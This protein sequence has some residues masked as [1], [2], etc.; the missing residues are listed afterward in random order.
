M[1]LTLCEKTKT[2]G[3]NHG[4]SGNDL[5]IGF[6][7]PLQSTVSEGHGTPSLHTASLLSLLTF[8]CE[9]NPRLDRQATQRRRHE[10]SQL[11]EET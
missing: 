6:S 7:R 4:E 9:Q 11:S 10:A 3:G 8:E 5:L 2:F 1:P